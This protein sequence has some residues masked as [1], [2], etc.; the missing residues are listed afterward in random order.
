[1]AS[2]RSIKSE[3]FDREERKL[4]ASDG[5][6]KK[7]LYLEK[8]NFSYTEAGESKQA[9]V[10][11]VACKRCAEKLVYRRLK[12]K[13]QEQAKAK[14]QAKANDKIHLKRKR[15]M[16]GHDNSTDDECDEKNARKKGHGASSSTTKKTDDDESFEE[17]LEGMF[18]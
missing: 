14:E 5:G 1:M 9:L 8:V 12:E 18:P 7:K 6:L 17:F 3:V 4:L 15:E 16:D 10:K 2:F 11:L 13:E